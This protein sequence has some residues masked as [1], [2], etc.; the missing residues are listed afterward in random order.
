MIGHANPFVCR[1]I[2]KV[3]RGRSD[4]PAKFRNRLKRRTT[5]RE[6]ATIGMLGKERKAAAI[7]ERSGEKGRKIRATRI[8]AALKTIVEPR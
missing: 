1:T 8:G 4:T 2:G 6:I 3:I 5:R 7:A